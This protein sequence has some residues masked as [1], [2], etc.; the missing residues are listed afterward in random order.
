MWV[1]G[2]SMIGKRTGASLLTFPERIYTDTTARYL[3]IECADS[4]CESMDMPATLHPQTLM[5]F[6]LWDEI[7]PRKYGLLCKIPAPTKRGFPKFVTTICVT[8]L[9]SRGF[10]IDRGYNWF[11][12]I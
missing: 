10:W 5:A 9:H 12:G 4:C 2:W 7:L 6:R 1:E 8:N 3:G 11:S